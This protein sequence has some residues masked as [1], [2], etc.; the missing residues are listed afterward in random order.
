MWGQKITFWLDE[1]GVTLKEEG[2]MGLTTIKSSAARAPR[3]I[4]GTGVEDLYEMTAIKVDKMLPDPMK[5]SYLR[6]QVAGI[7]SATIDTGAW[8]GTRQNLHEDVLE[9][10]REKVPS[11]SSYVLPYKAYGDEIKPFLDPEFNIES[12]HDEI[13]K[14]AGRITGKDKDPIS[15]SR[16]LLKWVY[17]N[18]EK[19]PVVSVPSA[20][21]VLR[22][23]MGDCNEHATLLTALLRASGIPARL[24]I[25]LVYTRQKFFYHA[26]TEAYL[27]EWISMDATQN[28]MPV[29]VTH[30]KLIEGNL[31]KQVEIAG[32]IGT[33]KLKVLDYQYD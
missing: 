19:R 12:D 32:L 15:V 20:I 25:G 23:R 21:E 27:G 4:E 24:N 5:L 17:K 26:W 28:Q 1:A 31:D 14:Q 6:L 30:I 29:D 2:F 22:T 10:R 11:K 13:I 3:D 9:I 7:D 16:K 8:A 18:L 33:L